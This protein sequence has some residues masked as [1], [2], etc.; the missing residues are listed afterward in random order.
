MNNRNSYNSEFLRGDGYPK[1]RAEE[2]IDYI[3]SD[4]AEAS[5]GKETYPKIRDWISQSSPSD[6]V[7]ICCGQ[8]IVSRQIPAEVKYTGIDLSESLLERANELY[9]GENR[10]F[11]KGN[12]YDIPLENETTEAVLSVWA[13]SHLQDLPLAA[14]ETARILK[15]G[16]S[17]LIITASPY[18]YELRKTFY[19]S[20]DP[21]YNENNEEIGLVGDF[22]LGDNKALS[23]GTLYFHSYEDMTKAIEDANLI[24]TETKKMYKDEHPDGLYIAISGIKK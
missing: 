14:K 7:E 19:K 6:V 4:G 8:G 2:Y 12:A 1:E 22:D 13:W 16:G 17:F 3:E 20:Y 23:Q 18:S 9:G 11:I 24:I 21:I 15:P 5:R 10:S